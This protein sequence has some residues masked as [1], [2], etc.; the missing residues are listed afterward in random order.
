[1][2]AEMIGETLYELPAGKMSS[3]ARLLVLLGAALRLLTFSLA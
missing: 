1:M 2:T 3:R